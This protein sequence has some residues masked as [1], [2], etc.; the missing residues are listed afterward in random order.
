ML[1]TNDDYDG[2]QSQ[3]EL[4]DAAAGTYHCK[5]Y[6]YSTAFGN[7]T[8]TV[9]AYMNPT[10]P[11]G[12]SALGGIERVYT[13]WEPAQPAGTAR[14]VAFD[15]TADEHIEWQYDNKKEQVNETTSA[16]GVSRAMILERLEE[17]GL[18]RDTEVLVTLFDSY[19]DGHYGGDSDG[20]AYVMND[21]GDT[22]HTLEGP[23]TGTSA[24]FG[25]F[26]L[27][28][29]LYSV[30]WDQTAPWLSEQS[31]EVVL[32]S[33][34][35]VVLG[36]GPAPSACFGI[37][38]GYVCGGPDLTVTSV[39]YDGWTGRGTVGVA[40]IGGLDAGYFYTMAFIQEPDTT[41]T[42]PPGYFQYA[43]DG[44]GLAAGDSAEL[45]M[46]S[47]LTLPGFVGGYDDS[48]YTYYAMV[49][50]YGMYAVSYTHLTLPTKA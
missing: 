17:I 36:S 3:V 9:D 14:A 30:E 49:D 27:A 38:E 13:S 18:T 35:T 16:R 42:Y 43:W 46:S 24:S 37:G 33:D 45:Y 11:T 22:L 5:V 47:Y 10:N 1:A 8:L 28:D 39:S 44:D 21:A 25:P 32:A 23:W 50:G 29:G 31:M 6:G 48:T 34:T 12:L 4:F 20:D 15:G 2:V 26:T 7:Y 41:A 40:N 19:G